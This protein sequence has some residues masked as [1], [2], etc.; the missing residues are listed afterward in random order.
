MSQEK[1][2]L[3]IRTM[4]PK[5]CEEVFILMNQLIEYQKIPKTEISLEEF[6]S[7]SGLFSTDDRK[8][9]DVIVAE[10]KDELCGYILYYLTYPSS[11]GRTLYMEDIFVREKFRKLGAG[12]ELLEEAVRIA[13]SN[14]CHAVKF[15]VLDWNPA[16]KFY[17]RCGASFD[18][19]SGPGPWLSYTLRIGKFNGINKKFNQS[20]SLTYDEQEF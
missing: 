4:D 16:V 1:S 13:D 5:D 17:E 19:E 20:S 10:M 8:F 12:R 3:V 6:K 18:G 2:P 7:A 9:Y 14:R 15:R 11:Y